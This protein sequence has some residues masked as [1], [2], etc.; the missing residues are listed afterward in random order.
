V[1]VSWPTLVVSGLP[2]GLTGSVVATAIPLEEGGGDRIAIDIG[3]VTAPFGSDAVATVS[4]TVRA[5]DAFANKSP[6]GAHAEARRFDETPP[7]V[8]A[9]PGDVQ[10]AS[11]ANTLGL[12][13]LKIEWPALGTGATRVL[14][15]SGSAL[16]DAAGADM[17]S[18]AAMSRPERAATLRSA[19]LVHADVFTPDHEHPYPGGAGSH[20]AQLNSGE[21]G[22]TVFTVQA[23]S[24]AGVRPAW[25]TAGT[26][27]VVAAAPVSRLPVPPLITE[28]RSGDRAITVFVAD[29]DQGDVTTLQLYRSRDSQALED[30]RTMRIVA[31]ILS[32]ATPLEMTDAD[33]YPD[34]DYWYRAVAIGPGRFL[35]APAVL[36]QLLTQMM[37]SRGQRALV[38]GAGTGYSAAVLQAIGLGVT[39]LE[40][41]KELA[42]AA[43]DRGIGVVE[44]PLPQGWPDGAPYDQI[45]IDG[46]V[47]HIPDAIVAQLADGGRL[48]VAI[49]DRGITRLVVGR[50]A[51]EAFGTLSIGD[52]GVPALPGFQ[53]PRAFSF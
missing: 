11:K 35:A 31:E 52:A 38:V 22:L 7:V 45:L 44:G 36:G 26:A 37:P 19:A 51:G 48:G 39:A 3:P 28:V 25:P 8:P 18:Y 9:M 47:E 24:A 4:A 16:L 42:A 12:C 27:F 23:S 5:V 32:I 13:A 33:L 34:I 41:D 21:T 2:P 6:F 17:D 14:R 1:T 29:V 53:R 49:A 43:R 20:V 15:A 46:A 40:S 30:V 10:I 50:K